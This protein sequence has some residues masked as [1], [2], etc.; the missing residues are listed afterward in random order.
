MF[1]L[2]NL[3]YIRAIN[4]F[5][6]VMLAIYCI[7]IF[8]FVFARQV[9][10]LKRNPLYRYFGWALLA[11]V[12]SS[13]VFCLIYIYYYNGGDTVSYYETSR[14]L[15]N[16]GTKNVASYFDVVTSSPSLS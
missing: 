13:I 7:V 14:S 16:L 6:W 3:S 8:A 15:V 2:E 12:I 9:M 10:M 5:E 1:D 4:P 11:K